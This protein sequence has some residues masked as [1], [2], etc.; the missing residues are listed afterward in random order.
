MNALP[1]D[2]VMYIDE[3]ADSAEKPA[4]LIAGT[5]FAKQSCLQALH[6]SQHACRTQCKDKLIQQKIIAVM[7]QQ[8]P[9]VRTLFATCHHVNRFVK[10]IS[11]MNC[12]MLLCN[13][14]KYHSPMRLFAKRFKCKRHYCKDT[15]E[16]SGSFCANCK[17]K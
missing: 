1:A 12:R 2:L 10:I 13:V 11:A 8:R 9:H 3:F 14:C 17:S 4:L 7:Y 6:C 16:P 5:K 15:C